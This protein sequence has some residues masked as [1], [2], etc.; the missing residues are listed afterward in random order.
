MGTERFEY[1]SP[2]KIALDMICGTWKAVIL[3]ELRTGTLRY[4]VLKRSIPRISQN[5][6]T[7][8]LREMEEDGLVNRISYREIPP[9]VEYSLTSFGEK[10]EPVLEALNSWGTDYFKQLEH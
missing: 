4:S 3:Q 10:A 7:K 8:Q 1:E 2:V 6:L 9:R 5:T